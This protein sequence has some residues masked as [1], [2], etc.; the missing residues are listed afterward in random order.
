[1]KYTHQ[2]VLDILRLVT[3]QPETIL[4]KWNN[5]QDNKSLD[6]TKYHYPLNLYSFDVIVDGDNVATITLAQITNSGI[7]GQRQSLMSKYLSTE[8]YLSSWWAYSHDTY[9][10]CYLTIHKQFELPGHPKDDNLRVLESSF[11]DADGNEVKYRLSYGDSEIEG[12]FA[13]WADDTYVWKSYRFENGVNL[14]VEDKPFSCWSMGEKINEVIKIR[15]R[16]QKIE[17]V[18]S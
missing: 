8:T 3:D 13:E 15:T 17:K 18:I 7:D 1:M 5:N 12:L 2:Q 9:L 16:D 10:D 6:L 4:S 14:Q 11:L